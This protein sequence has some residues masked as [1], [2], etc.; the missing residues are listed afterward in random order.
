MKDGL[1]KIVND[2]KKEGN[3][4]AAGIES[5]VNKLI[6]ETLDK[7]IEGAKTAS[8]TIGTEGNDLMIG[9]VAAQN[10][11]GV[12]GAEVDKLVKGIK[13]IV[14]VVLRDIGNAEAGDSKKAEDGSAERGNDAGEAGK[15]FANASANVDAKKAAVDAA[16]AVGAVTGADILQAMVKNTDAAKLAKHNGAANTIANQSGVLLKM[17]RMEL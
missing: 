1:N 12:A 2:M 6:S 13:E 17:L 11:G 4:N 10:N 14:D 5:A 15:L 3:P 7:I 16:K 9:N 8:E